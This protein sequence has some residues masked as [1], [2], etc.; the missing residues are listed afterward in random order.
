[1]RDAPATLREAFEAFNSRDLP[2]LR[3]L[4]H[5]EGV[6]PDTLA[7]G[8]E[9]RGVEAIMA[10]FARLFALARTDFQLIRVLEARADSLTV[11]AQILVQDPRGNIWSDT[12]AT[13]TY[14]FRDGLLSGLT[15][16]DGY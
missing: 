1:M 11:E 4:V 16:L 10:H 13:L 5:P 2:R 3:K 14:H 8:R 9:I 12:R 15:I 7:T 6:W